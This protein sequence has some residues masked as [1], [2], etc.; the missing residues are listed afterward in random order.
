LLH[1]TD[2]LRRTK[3]DIGGARSKNRLP[4]RLA[5]CVA[6]FLKSKDCTKLILP[7]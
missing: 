1:F 5:V 2:S 6:F 7:A 3:V 4:S